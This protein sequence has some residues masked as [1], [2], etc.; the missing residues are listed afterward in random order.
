MPI[1][2]LEGELRACPTRHDHVEAE[3]AWTVLEADNVVVVGEVLVRGEL[4][5]GSLHLVEHVRP[6]LKLKLLHFL[7][8][9]LYLGAGFFYALE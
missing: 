1:I 8:L 4:K 2:L 5:V 9:V 6:I 7:C 3:L